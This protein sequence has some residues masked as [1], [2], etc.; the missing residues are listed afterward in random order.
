MDRTTIA[1]EI[2]TNSGALTEDE[3]KLIKTHTIIAGGALTTANE[4]LIMGFV[5]DSYLA[6][7][8]IFLFITMINEME[9]A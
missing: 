5:S 6:L 4:D 8:G 2:Q 7:P 9:R 3:F 1:F